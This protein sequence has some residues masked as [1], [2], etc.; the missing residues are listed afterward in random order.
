MHKRSLNRSSWRDVF[1][2]KNKREIFI[3]NYTSN[4]FFF[5]RKG[6][7]RKGVVWNFLVSSQVKWLKKVEKVFGIKIAILHTHTQK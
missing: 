1:A 4:F 7:K 6:K 3:L 5:L 2:C